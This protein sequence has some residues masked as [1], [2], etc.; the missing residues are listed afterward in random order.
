MV[1]LDN[2]SSATGQLFLDDGESV[3]TYE[4]GT[5]TLLTFQAVKV[6]VC[7]CVHACVRACVRACSCACMHNP[8]PRLGNWGM[9]VR[10]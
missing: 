5:Y 8:I 2:T 3:G 7:V 10:E 1:A 9:K 6:C 4:S